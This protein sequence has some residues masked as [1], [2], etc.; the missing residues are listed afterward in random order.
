MINV[1][2]LPK[3]INTRNPFKKQDMIVKY[4]LDYIIIT[5]DLDVDKYNKINS[6]FL[7]LR[8]KEQIEIIS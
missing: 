8:T 7:L 6:K 5:Y 1:I 3:L 4:N 2:I